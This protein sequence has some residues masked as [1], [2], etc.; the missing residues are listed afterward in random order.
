MKNAKRISPLVLFFTL[1]ITTM[2]CATSHDG[3]EP[4]EPTPRTA[5]SD[6][7]RFVPDT[8]QTSEYIILSSEIEVSKTGI[9]FQLENQT[10]NYFLYGEAW[11]LWYFSN[12]IWRTFEPMFFSFMGFMF[13]PGE[14]QSHNIYWGWSLGALPPGEYIFV[15]SFDFYDSSEWAQY[16]ANWCLFE[17]L[18]GRQATPRHLNPDYRQ[19]VRL[20]FTI[21]EDSPDSFSSEWP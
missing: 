14:T 2:G 10:E 11:G 6:V 16:T 15:R 1:L 20:G 21:T 5:P 8:A 17:S 13:P 9:R 4:H 3:S 18:G 19:E 12:G 7:W